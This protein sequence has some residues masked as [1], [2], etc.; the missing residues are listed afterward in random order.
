MAPI[1]TT[2]WH[3]SG[4][5]GEPRDQERD[6]RIP[7]RGYWASIGPDNRRTPDGWSWTILEFTGGDNHEIAGDFADD[8]AAAKR[9][10]DQ[11]EAAHQGALAEGTEPQPP[12]PAA[13]ILPVAGLPD[14]CPHCRAVPADGLWALMIH[15]LLLKAACPS[16]HTAVAA[17]RAVAAR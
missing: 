11:W 17:V 8:E 7:G 16:C 10:V 1:N 4:H 5:D 14:R 13:L 9:A 12:A 6:F 2:Q 3:S 15:G